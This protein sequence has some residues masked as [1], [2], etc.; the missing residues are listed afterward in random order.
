MCDK[1]LFALLKNYLR[2]MSFNS[3]TEMEDASLQLLRSISEDELQQPDDLLIELYQSVIYI[4]GHNFSILPKR[5]VYSSTEYCFLTNTRS[6]IS[7]DKTFVP[8]KV[9]LQL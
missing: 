9:H 1:L 3:A 5:I 8:P 4:V 6:Y 2:G 7:N